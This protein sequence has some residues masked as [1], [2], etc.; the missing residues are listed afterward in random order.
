MLMSSESLIDNQIIAGASNDFTITLTDGTTFPVGSTVTFCAA[1]DLS[2]T[3][4]PEILKNVAS[5]DL[6]STQAVVRLLPS[7]TDTNAIAF[8]GN[9]ITLYFQVFFLTT[10][11]RKEYIKFDNGQMRGS[12]QLVKAIY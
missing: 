1:R 4:P 5:E 7:D 6:T 11:G 8:T 3:T 12:F 2:L 9:K 10:T